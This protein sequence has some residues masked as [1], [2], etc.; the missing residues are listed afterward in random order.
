MPTTAPLSAPQRLQIARAVRANERRAANEHAGELNV[1]PFLDI[2]MNVLMFVLATTATVFTASITPMVPSGRGA[3]QMATVHVTPTGYVVATATGTMA[4]PM[5]AGRYDTDGLSRSLAALRAAATSP[6]ER[7]QRA[8]QVSAVGAVPY[9]ELVRAI[10]ASRETR[11]GAH[12]L[13][14]EVTLG[15]VR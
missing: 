2:V 8:V 6:A 10:D 4:V 15:V 14:P 5:R 12:D 13:F 9:G 3:V 1:I 11:P 7:E